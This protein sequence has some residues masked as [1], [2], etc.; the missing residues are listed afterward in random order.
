MMARYTRQA[1]RTYT[2]AVI[3]VR[4]MAAS[5]LPS[6][7]SFL[8]ALCGLSCRSAVSETSRG[9]GSELVHVEQRLNEETA[10]DASEPNSLAYRRAIGEEP[11]RRARRREMMESRTLTLEECLQRAF[12]GSN[13]IEQLR[14]QM[15]LVGGTKLI[16][17]S[18]FLPTVDVVGQFEHA[19]AFEGGDRSED[20]SLVSAR[21]SQRILEWGKDNPI[22]L[23]LRSDQREALFGYENRVALVLS[24]VRRAFLFIQLKDQQ[25]AA[26]QDLLEQF[27]TQAQIKQQRMDA[28]NLSVKIEVLTAQLNVLNEKTRIN[29]LERQKF[30]RKAELLRLIGLPVGA[31]QVAF[32][33]RSDNFGL[34]GFDM[35][36]MIQLALAQNS[37]LA[38][39]EAVAAERDRAL[40]QLRYEY[41]PDLRFTG[42]YQ[43]EFGRA[44]AEVQNTDDTWGLDLIGEP[45]AAGSTKSEE[46]DGLGY[47]A[48][49]ASLPGPDP[50][51]FAA[52]QLGIPMA[53]GRAR[54]GRR[55]Q[56]RARLNAALAAAEDQQDRIELDVRQGYMFLCEQ[57][58]QVDLAQENVNIEKER[59]QIQEELRNAGKITDDQLETFRTRFFAAQD[60][61]F[62]QQ[63][64]LIE[65]QEDLRLAIRYFK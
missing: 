64:R 17:N 54:T 58:F 31:N 65:R 47:F 55:M 39:R 40:R 3:P 50:G 8:L 7:A 15:S 10:G 33:G 4:R 6:L 48:P 12:A 42:G 57:K 63:E 28:G 43:D 53:E 1:T 49:G 32:E 38:F 25:I 13:E 23:A 19:R 2:E 21:V 18:R 24:E 30:N 52:V 29:Q 35:D 16:A 45:G 62:D 44:G 14:E 36:G 51:W 37:E 26:R 41:A 60:N 5:V 11:A 34:E 59:F 46:W 61:L 22:D 27:E 9:L 56:A 20:A